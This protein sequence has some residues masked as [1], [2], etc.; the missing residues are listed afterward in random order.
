M[1]VLFLLG[2][3]CLAAQEPVIR[4]TVPLVLLP[5]SVTDQKGKP[6]DGLTEQDFL[7]ADDGKRVKHT[8]EIT[9]EPI[10]L[11][12]AVQTSSAA[13]PALAKIQRVGSMFEPLV[14]GA[15]GEAAIL[16]W[17]SRVKLWQAFTHSGDE[18]TRRMRKIMPD[19]GEARMNDAVVE[20]TRMLAAR[21]GFRRILVL[22]GETRDRGSEARLQEA[23]SKAQAANVTIYPVSYSVYATSFTSRG[24]ETFADTDRPVLDAVGPMNL[25]T[26]FSE[27]GRMA[28][29]NGAAALASYTGGERVSFTKLSGLEKVIA[30]VGRD[31]HSQYLLSFLADTSQRGV[32]RPV[33]VTVRVQN[34]RVRTRPG[35]WLE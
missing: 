33:T 5:V 3:L 23:I 8:L 32:Y 16:T 15:G 4:T 24:G 31:L 20:A 18:F 1:K 6:V 34:A 25:V 21:P 10:S 13:G 17:S 12:V 35:Y 27:I 28:S 26:V 14:V 11:V 19:G 29:E 22:I 7:V 30:A 9:N 2:A